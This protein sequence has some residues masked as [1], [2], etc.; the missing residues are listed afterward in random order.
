MSYLTKRFKASVRSRSQPDTAGSS[1]HESVI[2]F[3]QPGFAQPEQVGID[4]RPIDSYKTMTHSS[5]DLT[6]TISEGPE[7][8]W[9]ATDTESM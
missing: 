7:A 8:P 5:L 4:L 9:R 3:D 6:M 1:K 2:G